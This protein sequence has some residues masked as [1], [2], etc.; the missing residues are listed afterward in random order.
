[1]TLIIY[2]FKQSLFIHVNL[3]SIFLRIYLFET[4]EVRE[5]MNQCVEGQ[6]ERT[7]KQTLS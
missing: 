2:C 4:E 1:M 3:V 7:F 6:K 5:G